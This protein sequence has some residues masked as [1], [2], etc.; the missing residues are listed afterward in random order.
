MEQ[1]RWSPSLQMEEWKNRVCNVLKFG[2]VLGLGFLL[3]GL[4]SVQDFCGY[5]NIKP[6]PR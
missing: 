1:R 5:L 4:D 3:V 2:W 6:D